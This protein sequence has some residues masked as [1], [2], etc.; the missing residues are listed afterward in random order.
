MAELAYAQRL[1]RCPA[2]VGGSNPPGGTN[3]EIASFEGSPRGVYPDEGG[4]RRL[5]R[6]GFSG[7]KRIGG[8][9][10]R[11]EKFLI[12]KVV[13]KRPKIEVFFVAQLGLTSTM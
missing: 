10:R 12:K 7:Q 11:K 1:G 6:I 13:E 3:E 9:E 2:R 8:F 4:T 5:I